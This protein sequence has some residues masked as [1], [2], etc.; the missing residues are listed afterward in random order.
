[1]TFHGLT[2]NPFWALFGGGALILLLLY[3]LRF[4][5]KGIPL[6]SMIIWHRVLG[7]RRAPWRRILSL[8]LQLLM[9]FLICAALTDPRRTFEAPEVRL[10]VLIVDASASMAVREDETSRM[11]LA[12]EI[13]REVIED[14]GSLDTCLIVRMDET[15]TPLTTFTGDATRLER[16]LDRIEP[17]VGHEDFGAAV[18]LARLS[19]EPR[20]AGAK[21]EVIVVSDRVHP[22]PPRGLPEGVPVSHVVVGSRTENVGIVSFDVRRSFSLS[23]DYEVLVEVENFGLEEAAFDLVI[24]MPEA[25]VGRI[26]MTLGPGERLRKFYRARDLTGGRLIASIADMAG[27]DDIDAMALD[28]QAFALFDPTRRTRVLLV[29][30]GNLFLEVALGIHPGVDFQEMTPEEYRPEQGRLF[31]LVICDNVVPPPPW[32]GTFVF[33]NPLGETSPFRA[34][35]V[36]E[37]PLLTGWDDSHPVLRDIALREI[38]IPEATLFAEEPGDETLVSHYGRPLVVARETRDRKLLGVGFDL[39]RSDLPLRV[40]FPCLIHNWIEWVKGRG[41]SAVRAIGP[42]AGGA[43]VGASAAVP[44]RWRDGEVEVI[45]PDGSARRAVC[46]DGRVALSGGWPG[47]YR[48][49]QDGEPYEVALNFFDRAESSVV[50][51]R[52]GAAE[53]RA[54]ARPEL[55]RASEFFWRILLLAAL[56]LLLLDWGLFHRAKLY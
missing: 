47:F 7:K 29:S 42:E 55:P 30:W 37:Y 21:A 13:A 22:L 38:N 40:A 51:D 53:H 20:L 45:C 23:P 35:E 10:T 41:P 3:I 28:D 48:I 44:A 39:N 17:S 19:L 2:G 36:V 34:A 15:A 1:M 43:Y 6:S 50:P 9:L 11:A 31:D 46:E 33:L 8:L 18:D 49:M 16:A 25:V 5:R 27:G 54:R 12:R 4:R 26:P 14:L 52:S 24:H 56:A 32:E